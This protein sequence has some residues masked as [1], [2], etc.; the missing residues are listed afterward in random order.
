MSWGGV[1]LDDR[2]AAMMD[3]VARLLGGSVPLVATQGSWNTSVSASGG[4]HSG[5]GAIDITGE[6]MTTGQRDS[7]IAAMRQVGWAAWMRTPYQSDWMWHCHGI[8][9]QPGGKHDQGCLSAAAHSQVVD[10]YEGRNGLASGAPDDGPRQ[11]VGT[12]WES[13]QADHQQEEDDDMASKILVAQDQNLNY[14]VTPAGRAVIQTKDE[15]SACSRIIAAPYGDKVLQA[16]LDLYHGV[17]A[18]VTAGR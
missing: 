8:S 9:V 10:Y 7:L 6:N 5:G 14:L 15:L 1:P 12:T 2:S 11:W 13:Y 18:R 3:E 17:C 16:E 4:T